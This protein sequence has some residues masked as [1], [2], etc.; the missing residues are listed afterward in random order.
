M[1]TSIIAASDVGQPPLIMSIT[2][3]ETSLRIGMDGYRSA[4]MPRL[5][6]VGEEI[7]SVTGVSSPT[8]TGV[9]LPFAVAAADTVIVLP[10]RHPFESLRYNAT[11]VPAGLG[12]TATAP[13]ESGVSVTAVNLRADG[14][15]DATVTRTAG[16]AH[17]AGTR[18]FRASPHDLLT[19]TRGSNGTTAVAHSVTEQVERLIVSDDFSPS[20]YDRLPYVIADI[21]LGTGTYDSGQVEPARWFATDAN[22]LR[23]ARYEFAS[24]MVVSA[25][26]TVTLRGR[27]HPIRRAAFTINRIADAAGTPIASTL[28]P[29][30]YGETTLNT[31][32]PKDVFE[33]NTF[34]PTTWMNVDAT[35]AATYFELLAAD[36]LRL[37]VIQTGHYLVA[38]NIFP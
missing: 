13:T 38:V 1:A 10:E 25:D 8:H 34:V 7:L 11:A 12:G 2:A 15:W 28:W 20:F 9:D 19:V 4:G 21:R 33:T 22:G 18:L 16:V 31:P 32:G 3:A 24:H 29:Y 27:N 30:W 26:E 35:A 5:L 23:T 14:K 6:Q 36:P 17:A 37:R